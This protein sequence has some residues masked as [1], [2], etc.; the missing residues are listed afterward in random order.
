MDVSDETTSKY[1]KHNMQVFQNTSYLHTISTSN[2]MSIKLNS[3]LT[4]NNNSDQT[5]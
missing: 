3:I 5:V 1:S 2:K 4:T